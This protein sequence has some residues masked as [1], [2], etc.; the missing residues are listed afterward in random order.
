[1]KFLHVAYLSIGVFLGN[2]MGV[3]GQQ[4]ADKSDTVVLK[5][6]PDSVAYAFGASIARDL[7]RTG[8]QNVNATILA[9]AVVDVFAGK[10]DVLGEEEERELIMQAIT[11]AREQLDAKRKGEANAFMERNKTKP[12]IVATASGLQYEI[13]REGSGEKPS[14][15]DTVTVHYKGQLS[16]GNVFDSSYD[17][18][19]PTSFPLDRIIEGWMEGLQLMPM[20]SHYRFY[21]PYELGYGERGAG[22]DIPPYSPLIFDVELISVRRGVVIQ[23]IAEPSGERK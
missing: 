21:I 23:S 6:Q 16:N 3:N 10:A 17:R 15:N 1:M 12:G 19:E 7:K 18:G 11:V 5:S 20:G 22:Q 14:A 4:Q 8:V 9:Q 2:A 13:I